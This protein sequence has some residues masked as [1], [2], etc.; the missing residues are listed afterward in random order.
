[1]EGTCVHKSN[2]LLTIYLSKMSV[3]TEDLLHTTLKI[4]SPEHNSKKLIEC[5]NVFSCISLGAEFISCMKD[6][7]G[8]YTSSLLFLLEGVKLRVS[9]YT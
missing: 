2:Y 5:T 1:M 7:A 3:S 4:S 6:F 8:Q 9:K